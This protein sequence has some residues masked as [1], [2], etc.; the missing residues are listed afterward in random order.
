MTCNYWQGTIKGSRQ[1]RSAAATG[2]RRHTKAVC[3]SGCSHKQAVYSHSPIC[4]LL[5]DPVKQ[6]SSSIQGYFTYIPKQI[7][8]QKTLHS[9]A[10]ASFSAT[11]RYSSSHINGKLIH[12]EPKPRHKWPQAKVQET[13]VRKVQGSRH[14]LI[15]PKEIWHQN[16]VKNKHNPLKTRMTIVQFASLSSTLLSVDQRLSSR[17]ALDPSAASGNGDANMLVCSIKNKRY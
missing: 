13:S 4:I 5:F 8:A 17:E 16:R 6:G 2:V 11:Q 7:K 3:C 1:P 10:A 15:N 12:F 14:N 9:L